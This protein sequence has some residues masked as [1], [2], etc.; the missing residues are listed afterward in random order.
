MLLAACSPLT[1]PVTPIE[2]GI[3]TFAATPNP[4]PLNTGVVFSWTLFGSPF[5]CRVDA[6]N[7]G[8]FD[9]TLG[10]CSSATRQSHVYQIP[11]TYIARLQVQD[12]QGRQFEQTTV[13][14][15]TPPNRPP[16]I[17]RFEVVPGATAYAGVYRIETLDPDG[18]NVECQLD[19]DND[20]TFEYTF[21]RCNTGAMVLQ[22]H[23]FKPQPRY[24]SRLVA[25][26]LYAQVEATITIIFPLQPLVTNLTLNQPST[27]RNTNEL[28]L[29][30]QG[31]IY[32]TGYTLAISPNV[33]GYPLELPPEATSAR[34]AL[35]E[36]T[37]YTPITYQIT[38]TAHS[39][40]LQTVYRTSVQV[41]GQNTVCNLLDDLDRPP[42]GS[43]RQTMA[44]VPSEVPVNFWPPLRGTILLKG[45]LEIDR[46]LIIQ[47]PGPGV[48][49]VSGQNKWP[50][51]WVGPS[52]DATIQRLTF[53][54]GLDDS[55][56]AVY[57]NAGELR[58]QGMLLENNRATTQGGAV[59]NNA[60]ILWLEDSQLQGN[61]APRGGAVYN[62]G[63]EFL[64]YRS[65]LANNR[66]TVSDGGSVYNEGT[67]EIEGSRFV[68]SQAA[69][70]GGG[71][72]NSSQMTL[73]QSSFRNT[74]AQ[75]DG[76]GVYV[77]GGDLALVRV[78]FFDTTA[79]TGRGGAAYSTGGS[80]TL[81]DS[82]IERAKAQQDGGALYSTAATNTIL[83][84]TIVDS[85][86][87][88]GNGG[89][90]HMSGDLK[91]TDS[92][93][94]GN[95]AG[96]NGGAV[97]AT[98]ASIELKSSTIAS[99][100]ATLDGGAF[101]VD[102]STLSLGA[103]TLIGGLNQGNRANGYGGAVFANSELNLPEVDNPIISYNQANADNTGG[104][105]GG[106]FSLFLPD[107]SKCPLPTI[108]GVTNNLPDN[109]KIRTPDPCGP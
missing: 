11:G 52:G 80:L 24:V 93:L 38:L 74:S 18:D 98:N 103:G 17:A 16:I 72:Y 92:E 77:N 20:G 101:W 6:Q 81:E 33:E 41:W 28:F 43:L 105:T 78:N 58:L 55:G 57:N 5:T 2:P 90:L 85:K 70:D 109:Q 67:L 42:V 79:T 65:L 12:S 62:S 46:P 45:R 53:S 99:N 96:G 94:R 37:G 49:R 13:V 50:I 29:S 88:T 40:Y 82:R 95:Q 73:R 39:D 15:V 47:G 51:L 59:S 44:D 7:D 108:P 32:V 63:P 61:R 1:P 89:A 3:D 4:V 60:G 87:I 26:D 27:C 35:P 68:D 9:Y 84:S 19:V 22:P 66:A 75:N 86:T 8:I 64:I 100:F 31:S 102:Q 23:T 21:P 76:G 91:I 107:S 71:V 56:G 25:R 36:N 97:Y 69:G 83:R 104:E 48:I 106:G 30:W 54:N 14:E 34:L 10:N